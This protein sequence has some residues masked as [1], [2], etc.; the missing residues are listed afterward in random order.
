MIYYDEI[1]FHAIGTDAFGDP[2][3][4]EVIDVPAPAEIWPISNVETDKSQTTGIGVPKTIYRVATPFD[5]ETRGSYVPGSWAGSPRWSVIYHGNAMKTP[6]G[7]ERHAVSGRLDH[8]EFVA[9]D[10]G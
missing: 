8:Y 3:P 7:F 4:G 5:I 6:A 10:F 2:I 9:E 1:V